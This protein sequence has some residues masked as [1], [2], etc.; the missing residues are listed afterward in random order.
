MTNGQPDSILEMSE[1]EQDAARSDE[2][3]RQH[4]DCGVCGETVCV[5][6]A[7]C[8]CGEPEGSKRRGFVVCKEG[9]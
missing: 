6:G 7:G 1:A 9:C 8:D 2:F 4:P 5:A 3:H